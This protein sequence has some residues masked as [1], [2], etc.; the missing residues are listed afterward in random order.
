MVLSVECLDCQKLAGK[1][2]S[3]QQWEVN[4]ATTIVGYIP[5]N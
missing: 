2:V 5:Q 1:N 4:S 3:L